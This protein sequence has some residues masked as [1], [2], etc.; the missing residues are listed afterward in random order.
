MEQTSRDPEGLLHSDWKHWL[1]A[2]FEEAMDHT[3][4]ALPGSDP[5]LL[6]HRLAEV[7]DRRRALTRAWESEIGQIRQVVLPEDNL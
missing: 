1:M 2:A 5:L 7:N 4:A 6:E 3:Q